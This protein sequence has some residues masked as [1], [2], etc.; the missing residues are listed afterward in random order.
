MK[1]LLLTVAM[2]TASSVVLLAQNRQPQPLS[3]IKEKLKTTT[4]YGTSPYLKAFSGNELP[5]NKSNPVVTTVPPSNY[6]GSS[7][8]QVVIGTSYYDL[9]S[10][11]SVQN[12]IY[13]DN[14]TMGACWTFSLQT[15]AYS[16]RGAGYVYHD[17]TSW[18]AAPTTRVESQ[19]NG[20][21]S[22]MK[23]ASG[24]EVVISHVS[25][26]ALPVSPSS[27]N[28][29]TTAGAGGWTQ[30]FLSSFPLGEATLWPRAVAGGASGNTIHMI[31]ISTP[32]ANGGTMVNG[33]DGALNYSRSPD[34]GATWNIDRVAPPG[35]NSTE[36]AGFRA[37][38]YAIDSRNDVVAFTSG[39]VIDDWAIWKSTDNG[40]TF[41]R[42]V[43]MDFPWTLYDDATQITDIDFDGI[44]DTILTTGGVYALVLDN[45]GMAHVFASPMLVLDEVIGDPLGLFLS[46]DG[47]LYWNE[48]MGTNPPVNITFA[49]DV[50]GDGT[51]TFANNCD[52]NSPTT[53]AFFGGR[54]GNGGICSM[55]SAGV[56]ANN[57]LFVTYSALIE[58][59]E[60]FQ[61]YP[62]NWS[63]RNVMVIGSSDGGATWS[64]P[65]N[66]SNDDFGEAVFNSVA[67]NVDG[68]VSMFWQQD[69]FPG[70]FLQDPA[71]GV[72]PSNLNQM[73]YDC[74]DATTILN[75]VGV[76]EVL[77]EDVSVT[78]FP[79]PATNYIS[80]NYNVTEQV[81]VVIEIRNV[82]G[83]LIDRIVQQELPIGTSTF[84]VDI[85]SYASGLYTVNTIINDQ[86]YAE[87]FVKN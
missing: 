54:Y 67:R 60:S 25:D 34:G 79:N 80:L 85:N 68:C 64:F 44:A 46:T 36:Y 16:D 83:Q 12:R 74:I 15:A 76:N 5:I 6:K 63:Y 86:V 10:N 7:A 78:L 21:P 13:N 14:G 53:C 1:K 2:I 38:G 56:D 35:V 69:D 37:D 49:P 11:G 3:V 73:I 40:T 47:L 57:N 43:I 26:P 20:W 75:S 82:M 87:K 52:P 8:A 28:V 27:I 59:T 24:G 66:V 29:N 81:D 70:T 18:G 30:N 32:V 17:G 48:S 65:I 4:S 22:L 61:N 72:H 45:N 31:D 55:P 39:G 50:D 58:N 51:L 42:T 71:G 33:L 9:Q 19:R 62:N 84:D 23:L 41:T 77:T